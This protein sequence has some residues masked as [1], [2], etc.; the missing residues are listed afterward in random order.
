[1]ALLVPAHGG[2][3][4][5]WP[6]ALL[7][8][9]A[10][11]LAL[12]F[13]PFLGGTFCLLY[14][15]TAAFTALRAPTA[16]LRT[17]LTYAVAVLPVIAALGWCL[18][19]RTFDGAGGH[20]AFGL[21]RRASAS[22]FVTLLLTLGPALLLALT[23]LILAW[24]T[25][26][27]LLPAAVALVLGIGMFYGITLT[28]EPVWIGWRAGQIMLVT[29]PALAAA[30][31]AS[32]WDRGLRAA[33]VAIVAVVVIVGVPTTAID[34][35]NAQ[36][37]ANLEMGPGFRWTVSVSPSSQAAL[38]WIRERT[39]E[40]AVVQMSIKPRGRETWTLVPTFAERR[41]AAGQPISL[42]RI[43]E[44]EADSAEADT[45]FSTRTA[46]EAATIARGMRVD[47]IYVDRVEREAYG[48][49]I[50]K[51]NTPEYFELA[52]RDGDAAVYRVR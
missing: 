5:R 41:L 45:I 3:S 11:G 9:L 51:F 47:Y 42:L 1:M 26:F 12:T 33:A 10:L 31:L 36:D 49:A 20:V 48:A 8:G 39:P 52:F 40:D 25:P 35:H 34:L 27:R 4:A 23:G 6:A 14:G 32:L 50:D 13:S 18:A 28:A 38:A 30:G 16:W 21:S 43:P 2:A 29:I 17:I 15:L 19:N 37:I 46:A 24:R 22:P 7:A 44:Y